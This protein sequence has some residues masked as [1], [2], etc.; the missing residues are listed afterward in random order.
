[1]A[2]I[3]TRPNLRLLLERRLVAGELARFVVELDCPKPLPV[4]AVSLTL[5]GDVVWFSTS[6]YGRHRHNSRFLA[7]P[8]AL[9]DQPAELPAG[10]HRLATRLRLSSGLPGSWEGDRLAIEY[11]VGVHVDIPWWPDKRVEFSVQV[12]AAPRLIEPDDEGAAVYASHF[13]GPPAKGPYLELSLGRRTV[14]PGT[15]MQLS[16][17]L[18]NVERNRYRKLDV[19]IIALETLPTGL[20]GHY[21]HEHMVGRWSVGLD[22]HS[23]ELQPVPFNLDL[24]RALAP[25]FDL[26]GC[27]LQWVMQVEADVAWGVNPKL[28]F[29]IN[30]STQ[31]LAIDTEQVAPLAVGSERLRLIWAAVAKATN[32]EHV[33]GSLRGRLGE[34]CVEVHRSSRDGE[35]CVMGIVEFPSL[36]VG[37]HTVRGRRSLLGA[38]ALGLATR[39]PDQTAVVTAALGEPIANDSSELLTADDTSLRFALP[40]PGLELDSL[41]EFVQFLTELASLIERLPQALPPPAVAREHLDA[42]RRAA[43]SLMGTL[44][45]ADLQIVLAREDQTVTIVTTYDDDGGLRSTEFQLDPGITIPSRHHLLWTGDFALPSSEL[46]LAE[47][48]LAPSWGERGRIALQIDA[49]RVRLFLPAPL[50][51]PLLERSRVEALLAL[52]RTLRGE[53]GPYR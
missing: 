16:A 25:G 14:D 30:I 40:G 28:R 32:L 17:A 24:P 39:D 4:E 36:A 31:P 47:L 18:G 5:L 19:A 7:Y 48:T 23:G 46:P 45:V 3:K 9:L 42:W 11:S 12:A 20:G 37:L 33:D 43:Q 6:E 2:L 26:H 52:G 49:E 50:P 21:V 51:D 38:T 13:G 10:T 15:P 53:Q 41:R 27:K 1:M 29:P 44:R 34:T 8:V 22:N 35:S